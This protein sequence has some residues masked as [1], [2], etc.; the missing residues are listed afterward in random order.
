[1]PAADGEEKKKKKKM[2]GLRS[3]LFGAGALA[4]A[5]AAQPAEAA[6][7]K[8]LQI[9]GARVVSLLDEKLTPT[10]LERELLK[11]DMDTEADRAEESKQYYKDKAETDTKVSEALRDA[12]GALG[13]AQSS[14][15]RALDAGQGRTVVSVPGAQ[16]ITVELPKSQTTHETIEIPDTKPTITPPEN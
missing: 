1:M 8:A 5:G 11:L 4:A 15:N 6:D 16:K 14:V 7:A 2:G 12:K 9:P 13:E 10:E 3:L